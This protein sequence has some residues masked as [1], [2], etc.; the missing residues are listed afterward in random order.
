M[1]DD[2]IVKLLEEIRDLQKTHIENYKVALANQQLAIETQRSAVRRS[3]ILLLVVGAIVIAL[4]LLPMFWWGWMSTLRC[5]L[6]R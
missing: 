4:Y 3:R 5:A 2:Q 1:P 6:R